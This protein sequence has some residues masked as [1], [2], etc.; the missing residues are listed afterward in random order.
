[1][2]AIKSIP[3]ADMSLGTVEEIPTKKKLLHTLSAA[4]KKRKFELIAKRARR[5]LNLLSWSFVFR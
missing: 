5:R 4:I 2:A 1:V 3:D